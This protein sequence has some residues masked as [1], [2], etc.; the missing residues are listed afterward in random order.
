MSGKTRILVGGRKSTAYVMLNEFEGIK[1]AYSF[2]IGNK[3]WYLSFDQELAEKNIDIYMYDHT[4]NTYF[5]W[6]KYMFDSIN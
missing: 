3:I 4:I 2:G 1:I 5:Y 6:K